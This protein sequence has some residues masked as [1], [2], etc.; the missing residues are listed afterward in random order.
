[1]NAV[2]N[3]CSCFGL[4]ADSLGRVALERGLRTPEELAR[5]TKAGT[6]C[7]SCAPDLDRLLEALWR[8]RVAVAR[9]STPE[10]A[11]RD[12]LRPFL[13]D[14]AWELQLIDVEANV[15]RVRA[16]A[17]RETCAD[18]EETLRVFVEN[19]IKE[20]YRPDAG[21]IFV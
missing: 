7:R 21:V 15:V 4:S 13:R 9:P 8:G 3:V 18:A 16:I 1:M 2:P 6:G 20:M 17:R 10:N 5:A 11:V 19:R 12:A 14:S